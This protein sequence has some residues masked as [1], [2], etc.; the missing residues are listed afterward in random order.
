ML[1]GVGSVGVLRKRR[2]RVEK[3]AA[4]GAGSPRGRLDCWEG[5]A[6]PASWMQDALLASSH[7]LLCSAGARARE[8]RR[9]LAQKI[10]WYS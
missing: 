6:V 2:R 1:R 5:V 8:L 4:V 9:K 10:S 7:D 3:G